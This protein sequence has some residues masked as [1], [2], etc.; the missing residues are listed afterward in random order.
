MRQR[1]WNDCRGGNEGERA[2]AGRKNHF[3]KDRASHGVFFH[4]IGLKALRIEYIL[5][6]RKF[7]LYTDFLGG[8]NVFNL[9]INNMNINMNYI[10]CFLERRGEYVSFREFYKESY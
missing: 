3:H 7:I 4:L 9:C 1:R 10:H 5:T 8:M 2:L 6:D